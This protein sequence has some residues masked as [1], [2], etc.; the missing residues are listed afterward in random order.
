MKFLPFLCSVC[1]GC[2]RGCRARGGNTEEGEGEV[3]AL[4]TVPWRQWGVSPNP[5]LEGKGED[6]LLQALKDYKSGKKA[7]A[8]MKAPLSD[9][10]MADLATYYASLK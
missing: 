5:A 3:P 4:R 9:Q 8:A 10:D 6:E 2:I 7:N 1:L